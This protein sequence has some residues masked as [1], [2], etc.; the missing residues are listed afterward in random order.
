MIYKY[1]HNEFKDYKK[2]MDRPFRDY[3]YT[4]IREFFAD[5]VRYYYLK[6]TDPEPEYELRTYPFLP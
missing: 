3:S 2:K 6:Y 1:F 4:D 5:M